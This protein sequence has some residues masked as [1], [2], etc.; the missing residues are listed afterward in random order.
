MRWI[1]TSMLFVVPCL[2]GD[3]P[4]SHIGRRPSLSP[5]IRMDEALFMPYHMEVLPRVD[6]GSPH[7]QARTNPRPA[8]ITMPQTQG[9]RSTG[10]P[11]YFMT[12]P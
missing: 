9:I 5:Y 11:T 1:F 4:F 7:R 12:L 2:G 8:R 6:N 10:H 3:P